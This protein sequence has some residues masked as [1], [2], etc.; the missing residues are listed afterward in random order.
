VSPGGVM[1]L[2]ERVLALF[3]GRRRNPHDRNPIEVGQ[4]EPSV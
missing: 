3:S 1:G 4:A 2:W